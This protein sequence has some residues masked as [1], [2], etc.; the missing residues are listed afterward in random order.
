MPSTVDS[1]SIRRGMAAILLALYL[2]VA[3][4]LPAADAVLQAGESAPVVHVESTSHEAHPRPHDHALCQVCRAIERPA[5]G[6]GP[7]GT[8]LLAAARAV[9][10][11]PR[12]AF[13][14]PSHQLA[15]P[16]GARAP[17]TR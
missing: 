4:G 8:P 11:P 1:Q 5:V 6:A 16:L 14:P 12:G 15:A 2:G 7:H 10:Q 9:P 13:T 17:P 3:G